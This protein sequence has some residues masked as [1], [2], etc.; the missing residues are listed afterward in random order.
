MAVPAFDMLYNLSLSSDYI[1]LPSP[2]HVTLPHENEKIWIGDENSTY[3]HA[4][5]VTVSPAEAAGPRQRRL[6]GGK[7]VV[8]AVGNDDIIVN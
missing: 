5:A 7:H 8:Q 4:A 6:E 3:G 1:I 2:F